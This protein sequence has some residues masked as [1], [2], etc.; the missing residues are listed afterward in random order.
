[1]SLYLP[2]VLKAKKPP[3]KDRKVLDSNQKEAG[4][5]LNVDWKHA[6]HERK[7]EGRLV[8][9][10]FKRLDEDIRPSITTNDVDLFERTLTKHTWDITDLLYFN[11]IRKF[12]ATGCSCCSYGLNLDC[13]HC[14][15]SRLRLGTEVAPPSPLKKRKEAVAPAK[16]PKTKWGVGKFSA[17]LICAKECMN[18]ANLKMHQASQNHVSTALY[19]YDALCSA[20][21]LTLD[22]EGTQLTFTP[23]SQL[24]SLRRDQRIFVCPDAEDLDTAQCF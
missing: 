1:M 16:T 23:H 2:S 21:D 24:G 5:Q 13:S 12:T 3:S 17:C 7:E 10:C 22:W 18:A 14:Y 15:G 19:C 8:F 11:N 20:N 9:Y 6:V 4:K